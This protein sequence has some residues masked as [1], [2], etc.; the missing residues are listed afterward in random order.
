M[1]LTVFVQLFSMLE[2]DVIAAKIINLWPATGIIDRPFD[3]VYQFLANLR[4]CVGA[5]EFTFDLPH[6]AVQRSIFGAGRKLVTYAICI[7]L[8]HWFCVLVSVHENIAVPC[9]CSVGASLV[10]VAT[11]TFV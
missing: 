5:L 8:H 11:R 2:D 10:M 1:I 3:A 9:T 4:F 6:R 7:Q